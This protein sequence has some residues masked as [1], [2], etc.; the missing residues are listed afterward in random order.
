MFILIIIFCQIWD[1]QVD[2]SS[3]TIDVIYYLEKDGVLLPYEDAVKVM[4]FVSTDYIHNKT[5]YEVVD[6]V[7]RK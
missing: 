2:N 3:Q 4:S 6:K 5:G 7:R 1:L